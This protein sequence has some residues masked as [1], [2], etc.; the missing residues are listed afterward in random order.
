[1][2]HILDRM[3]FHLLLHKAN[4]IITLIRIEETKAPPAI[5][6]GNGSP[7]QKG[8]TTATAKTT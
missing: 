1:M 2:Q 4:M 8:F 3:S 6:S 7:A 5:L